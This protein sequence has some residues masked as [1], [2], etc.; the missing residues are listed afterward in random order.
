[1]QTNPSDPNFA[2]S[3]SSGFTWDLRGPLVIVTL[4]E[5]SLH[6]LLSSAQAV[7][8][9]N[10]FKCS[11]T[12]SVA[13]DIWGLV[14]QREGGRCVVCSDVTIWGQLSWLCPLP[15]PCALVGWVRSKNTP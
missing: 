4:F 14:V 13:W 11:C 2:A 1:M 9:A 8:H 7:G 15:S 5:G 10:S 12:A 3:Y 6:F